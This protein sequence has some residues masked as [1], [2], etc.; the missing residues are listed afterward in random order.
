MFAELRNNTREI[1]LIECKC[2]EEMLTCKKLVE[3][4]KK[5]WKI[6]DFVRSGDNTTKIKIIIIA[7]VKKSDIEELITKS[8]VEME[9]Y[10]PTQFYNE[11]H[12]ALK[13]VSKWMF[14]L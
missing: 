10:T 12:E 8:K 9:H 3:K 7:N 5:Y 4:T 6:A 2:A 1:L 11:N 14:G 13:G